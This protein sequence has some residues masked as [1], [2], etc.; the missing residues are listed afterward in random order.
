M[1]WQQYCNG[2]AEFFAESVYSCVRFP[3]E[4]TSEVEALRLSVSLIV[5]DVASVQSN[6]GIRAAPLVTNAV[7]VVDDVDLSV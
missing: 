5:N 4:V 7:C 6:R 2:G 3:H 1:R